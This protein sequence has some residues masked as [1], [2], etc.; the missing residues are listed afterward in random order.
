MTITAAVQVNDILTRVGVECGLEAVPDPY[1]SPT[2][3]YTQMRFLLQTAGEELCLAFPWE[4]LVNTLLIT[5]DPNQADPNAYALPED[6]Q[7]MIDQSGWNLTT[8]EPLIGPLSSQEWNAL[9]G[10]NNQEI[11]RYAFRIFDGKL[12]IYPDP[13]AVMNLSFEYQSRGF[14][15]YTNFP[16]TPEYSISSGDN[17][18]LFDRTLITR[19]LK[20]LW[21]EAKG[22]DTTASLSAFNQTFNML[23][24]KDKGGRIL[25]AGRGSG[26]FRYLNYNNIPITGYGQ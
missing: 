14:I 13:P 24:G 23:T 7:S 5:T 8:E 12:Q 10:T 22:F 18:I 21:L 9:K 1:G 26:G 15:R 16:D 25:D 4:F 3:H 17:T 20:F 11:I 6:F 2:Q 19:F